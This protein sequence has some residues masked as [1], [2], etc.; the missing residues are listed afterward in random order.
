MIIT[1][2]SRALGGGGLCIFIYLRSARRISFE[3]SKN[4]CLAEREYI[5][6]H[7]ASL[8]PPPNQ[9]SSYS[10]GNRIRYKM[11]EIDWNDYEGTTKVPNGGR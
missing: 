3:T 4:I 7:P 5:N 2:I 8:P 1:T 11:D 9:R 6:I 10:P